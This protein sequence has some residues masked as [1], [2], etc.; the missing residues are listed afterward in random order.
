MAPIQILLINVGS[1][2][3]EKNGIAPI[4]SN[5][6]FEYWPIE[7]KY[8]GR[9]TPRFRDLSYHQKVWK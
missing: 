9:K 3:N 6:R 8:P 7:E 4:Y 5:G 1:N 2:S